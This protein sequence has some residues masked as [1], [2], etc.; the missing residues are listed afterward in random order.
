MFWLDLND[1]IEIHW[2]AAGEGGLLGSQDTVA[3]SFIASQ[4]T[5]AYVHKGTS[6]TMTFI[7]NNVYT[8]LTNWVM[9]MATE[10]FSSCSRHEIAVR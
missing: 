5:T 6:P 3:N 2:Y 1:P 4:D 7:T 9:N 10:C 8:P